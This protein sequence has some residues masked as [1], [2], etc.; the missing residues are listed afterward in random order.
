M[1]EIVLHRGAARLATTM[2]PA[3]LWAASTFAQTTPT[4]DQARARMAAGQLPDAIAQMAAYLHAHADDRQARI[5]YVNYLVWSGDYARAQDALSADPALVASPQGRML[6][7]R[8]LAWAGWRDSAAAI[9][10]PLLQA[11]PDDADLNYTQALA[12]RQGFIPARALPFVDAFARLRPGSKDAHDLALGTHLPM[13][14]W[15]A[16]GYTHSDDSDNVRHDLPRLYGQWAVN[17]RLRLTGELDRWRHSAPA[18]GPFA[19]VDGSGAVD[20]SRG[21]FGLRWAASDRV[22][23]SAAIGR[24]ELGGN[25][26]SLWQA[27]IDGRPNDNWSLRASAGRDRVANSPLSLSLGVTSTAYGGDLHWT[28]DLRWVGDLHL[29]HAAYSDGNTRDEVLLAL[30]RAVIRRQG[31][32]LDLGASG[33]WFGYDFDPGHGYYAPSSYRRLSLTAIAYYGFSD[34]VGLSMQGGLGRQRDESFSSWRRADDLSAELVMG[35]FSPWELRLRAAYSERAQSTGA[36]QGTSVGMT[37]TY[38]H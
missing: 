28:P 36:Y 35:I 20:E 17:E 2:L 16:L 18:S 29:G 12:L 30:R 1:A 11:S 19:A 22:L 3:L 4:A 38:R 8:L 6:H 14:S 25:G 15:I 13:A 33:E 37:L 9:N 5:D 10:A 34:N 32:Q 23:L 7:A 31:L 27:G 24:S 26:V 21:L